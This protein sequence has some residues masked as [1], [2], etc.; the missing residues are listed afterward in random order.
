MTIKSLNPYLIFNGNA[1]QVVAFY[2]RALGARVEH[3]MHFDQA[4]GMSASP[5]NKQRIMHCQLSIDGAVLM[6]ADSMPS[7]PAPAV[8]NVHVV[9]HFSDETDLN[10]RFSALSEG[11]QVS[12]PVHDAFWGAKFGMLVDQFGVDWMLIYEQAAPAS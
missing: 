10:A 7:A 1:P 5:E 12:F 4:P 3:I 8:S 11:G 2:E 6:L 9:L